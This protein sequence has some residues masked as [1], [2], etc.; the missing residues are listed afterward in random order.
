MNAYQTV[1]T[2]NNGRIGRL[3]LG[4]RFTSLR[5]PILYPVVS[6]MT[7]SKSAGRGLHRYLLQDLIRHNRPFLSQVLHF[8]DFHPRVNHLV[9]WREKSVYTRLNEGFPESNYNAPIFLDSGG[10]KLRNTAAVNLPEFGIY[11]ETEADDILSLQLDLGGPIIASLDY[12]LHPE[13]DR[14]EIEKRM[15]RSL[16]NAIH[17]AEKLTTIKNPPYL[18]IC[19]HGGSGE[20]IRGYVTQVFERLKGFPPFGLAIGSLVSLRRTHILP[21]I[22]S[23]LD[24]IPDSERASVPVHAFGCSGSLAPILAYLGIDSFDSTSYIQTARSLSYTDP[25]TLKKSKILEMNDLYCDCYICRDIDLEELQSALTEAK[26]YIPTSTGHYKS[27][28]YAQIALHNFEMD[29]LNLENMA[30]AIEAGSSL[31]MLTDYI[32][33]SGCAR[34][35]KD[36]LIE[37]DPLFAKNISKT[38]LNIPKDLQI[39]KTNPNQLELFEEIDTFPNE[40]QFPALFSIGSNYRPPQGKR[41]LLAIPAS[42]K[43]PYSLSRIYQIITD[44]LD[45]AFGT[46]R[47]PIHKIIL[48]GLYGPVP[49]EYESDSTIIK[50]DFELR[51][52]DETYITLAAERFKDYLNRYQKYYE[53]IICYATAAP[54]RKIIIL[55]QKTYPNVILLPTAP[56]EETLSNFFRHI[57]L[58]ELIEVLAP[59]WE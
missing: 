15:A 42:L 35:T 25:K 7:G 59:V 41:I 13:L 21:L 32:L 14:P 44:K 54:Y 51:S 31:E 6:F 40:N 45:A 11:S 5:T 50:D 24:A 47:Q 48:S 30:M 46:H 8:L 3:D 55:C 56:K 29:S 9:Y 52:Q 27:H 53:L 28:Y 36:W 57:Y 10:F 23:V 19:C 1:I 20:D 4:A 22:K 33:K 49:E 37:N 16:K 17:I 26:S 12:P 38:V 2:H 18:Y 58:D 39:R 34:I 43:K